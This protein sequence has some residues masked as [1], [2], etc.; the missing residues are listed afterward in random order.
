MNHYSLFCHEITTTLLITWWISFSMHLQH[1]PPIPQVFPSIKS[2]FFVGE[3]HF[4]KSFIFVLI[5]CCFLA[6][7]ASLLPRCPLIGDPQ[8]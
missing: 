6:P 7:F 2:I 1:L 8:H 5:Q 3:A 4:A